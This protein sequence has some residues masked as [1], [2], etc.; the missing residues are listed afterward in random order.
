MK[1]IEPFLKHIR[2]ECIYLENASKELD[3]EKFIND[4][5]LKR[6]FARSLEIIG[7]AVKSIPDSF[8]KNYTHIPWKKIAGLRNILIHKYFGVDYRNLWKI[9][10]EDIPKLKKDINQILEN[11]Q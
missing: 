6:A 9:I 2:E 1:K 10:K 5:T 7:E 4:E 3:F 11:L 8:K